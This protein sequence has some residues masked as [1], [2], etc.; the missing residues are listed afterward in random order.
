[1]NL[2]LDRHEKECEWGWYALVSESGVSLDESL[3]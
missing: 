2:D 3:V 1:M